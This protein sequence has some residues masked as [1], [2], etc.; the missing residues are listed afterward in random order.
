MLSTTNLIRLFCAAAL[1]VVYAIALS[2][3][4]YSDQFNSDIADWTATGSWEWDEDGSAANVATVDWN[5]RSRIQSSS[6]GGAALFTSGDDGQLVSPPLNVNPNQRLYVQFYHYVRSNGGR[7][8]LEVYEAGNLLGEVQLEPGLGNGDETSAGRYR[9]VDISDFVQGSSGQIEF[10]FDVDGPVEFWLVDDVLVTVNPQDFPAFPLYFGAFLDDNGIPN[11]VGPSQMPFVPFEV[12]VDFAATAT[13][14]VRTNIR[15]MF[16]I[17]N[18]RSCVCDRL[19]VWEMSGGTFFDPNTGQPLGDPGSILTGLLGPGTTG[20]VDDVDF[21]FLN[22]DELLSPPPAPNAPLGPGAL[23]SLVPAPTD[24][25]RIAIL[26][27]G[28]DLDH[29]LLQ[30]YL[31]R[32]TD[33][34][35]NN[36]DEDD[37]CYTDDFIGWNFVEDNN[38]PTDNHSHGTHVAGVVAQTLNDCEGCTFQFLPYKTH[39]RFGVGTLFATSCAVLQAAVNDNADVINA[40]W[41]FYGDAT[42]ILRNAID[43]AGAYGALIVAAA[44]NDTLNLVADS[45]YP[46]TYDLPNVVSVGAFELLGDVDYQRAPFTNYGAEFVNI[47]AAGVDVNSSVPDDAFA[48]KSGTSMAAPVV[49]AAASLYRCLNEQ[50]AVT[51]QQEVLDTALLFPDILGAF[52]EQGRVVNVAPFCATDLAA[53]TFDLGQLSACQCD[54]ETPTVITLSST[55]PELMGML[56]VTDPG[57][58]RVIDAQSVAFSEEGLYTFE[59]EELEPGDYTILLVAFDQAV[60]IILSL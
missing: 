54:P 35:G 26:D 56:T 7:V 46:A 44:G 51:V 22:F 16:P 4:V 27:T 60:E 2:A 1:V 40:S 29:P 53:I 8:T 33:I 52:V 48:V 39:D 3:Q 24:A 25:F 37:N 34:A 12:V 18:V 57:G 5:L 45:Q 50:P 11:T 17:T 43:T 10:A 59:L 47:F 13:P 21:N 55:V 42:G 23:P 32:S 58:T 15:S 41:G 6:R 20:E 38:N 31:Y 36:L 49:T 9:R 30:P 28:L 19:E 14:T